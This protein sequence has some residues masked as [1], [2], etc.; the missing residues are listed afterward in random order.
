L[1]HWLLRT[2]AVADIR[3][4]LALEGIANLDPIMHI[5]P[6]STATVIEVADTS[7]VSNLAVTERD[8]LGSPLLAL[9]DGVP[10]AAHPLLQKHLI[11]DDQFNLEP[12]AL[13]QERR[14]GTAMAS[15]IIHGD[16]NLLE[17]PLPKLLHVVRVLGANVHF[18]DDRLV[19]DLIY[20]AIFNMLDGTTPTAPDVLLVNLSLGNSRRPF[21][22]QL[23]PWARLIDRLAYQYGLLFLVSAGNICQP[24]AMKSFAT[25]TAFEDSAK[26]ARAKQ[27]LLAV[28][29]ERQSAV[30][31]HQQKQSMG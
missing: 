9:L 12:N 24:L 17:P 18:P 22:G 26:Q 31:F 21:H 29:T 15:L 13:V 14:H 20:Q 28:D 10:I 3:N 5:R 11:V 6:Q 16:R 19:V 1:S 2:L 30:Y 4:L 8:L 25:L 23:S 27:V 7:K